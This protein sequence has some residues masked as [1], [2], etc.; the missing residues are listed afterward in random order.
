[1]VRHA[2]RENDF[3]LY[4]SWL[5]KIRCYVEKKSTCPV[6]SSLPN[7]TG[8]DDNLIRCSPVSTL[9]IPTRF[10]IAR[11]PFGIALVAL[12]TEGVYKIARHRCIL[13]DKRAHFAPW[14]KS[15]GNTRTR[16]DGT[17]FSTV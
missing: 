8:V 9:R 7:C 17:C 14:S 15:Y 11:D 5:T 4:S 1:M 10:V 3:R 6:F 13:P 12:A 2:P 16:I